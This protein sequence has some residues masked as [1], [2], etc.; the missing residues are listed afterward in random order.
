MNLSEKLRKQLREI[1][2]F[3]KIDPVYVRQTTSGGIATILV[4]VIISFLTCLHVYDY[5]NPVPSH[6]FVVDSLVQ[7]KLFID[8]DMTVAMP[9]SSKYPLNN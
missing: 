8:I 1:D 9:C 7:E 5:I 4:C 2:A 6:S 3:P